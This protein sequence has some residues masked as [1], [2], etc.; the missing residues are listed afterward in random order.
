LST[1]EERE[2]S[3]RPLKVWKNFLKKHY[4]QFRKWV[5]KGGIRGKIVD[6]KPTTLQKNNCRSEVGNYSF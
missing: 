1:F 6:L 3:P 5:F 2:A 4:H